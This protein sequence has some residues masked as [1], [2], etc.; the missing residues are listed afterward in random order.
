MTNEKLAKALGVVARTIER[1]RSQ[2]MPLPND[3]ESLS[4]WRKRAQNWRR[5]NR[6]LPGPRK[7]ATTSGGEAKGLDRIRELKARILEIELAELEGRVHSQEDCERDDAKRWG[8]VMD[9]IRMAGARVARRCGNQNP[10][11]EQ[12]QEIYDEEVRVA[13]ERMKRAQPGSKSA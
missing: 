11:P 4:E 10:S 9:A 12:V 3:G 13:I 1:Y 2:G 7:R 5:E 6:R 8:Q